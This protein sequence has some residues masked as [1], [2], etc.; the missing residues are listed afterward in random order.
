MPSHSTDW[1]RTPNSTSGGDPQRHRADRDR[2]ERSSGAVH[3]LDKRWR[4]RAIGV[5]Y[6]IDRRHRATAAGLHLL[7]VSRIESF[8]RRAAGGARRA[9]AGDF[10]VRRAEPADDDPRR[11]RQC[12]GEAREQLTKWI[13][14]GGVLVRFAGPR[15]A[16]SE[17]DLVPVKLRRGGRTLGGASAGTAAATLGFARESPFNGM[18]V[19]SDVTVTR[20]VL[21]EPDADYR[22]HL[23]DARRWHAAGDRRAPGKGVIV[24][25]HVTA[26]TRWSDLPS[27]APSS[28]CS[29]VSSPSRQSTADRAKTRRGDKQR[30]ARRRAAEPHAR[31]LRRFRAAAADRAADPGGF[32]GP[33]R[34]RTSARLLWPAGRIARCEHAARRPI[35]WRG[36]I[37]RRSTRAGRH[38]GWA[39]RRICAG[40]SC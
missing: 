5:D 27:P 4:R 29:S 28:T 23:G 10:A 32:R 31:R 22:S 11:R 14:D 17:D 15:L 18:A 39:S 20:Q 6:R 35:A 38:I 1:R 13:D 3:L 25:F 36:W 2:G 33:R 12:H 9:G 21:A 34:C 8:R 30:D 16:A 7:F 26:D 24:L 19:P 40:R 37:S